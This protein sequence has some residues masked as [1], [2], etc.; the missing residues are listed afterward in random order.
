MVKDILPEWLYSCLV[1]NY[2]L[3]YIQEIRIRKNQPIQIC[4]QGKI[5]E[6]T[7]DSGLY[8]KSIYATDDLITYIISV[9]TKQS[10]YAYE[11][12]IKSGFIVSDNGI[13][14]GLCGT[15]VMENGEVKFLK[16]ITSLNIRVGHN[17][18]DCSNE[19]LN[20]LVSS[21]RVKN[22]LI[23]SAPGNGKTTMLRDII[24][25]LSMKYNVANIMVVDEKNEIAGENKCFSLGK[26]V[27]VLQGAN[28]RFGFYESV[29]VMNPTVIATDELVSENDIEG[30]KFAI[31]SGVSVIATMHAKSID[32]LKS[33]IYFESII[34][35]KY[36]ERIVVLS[37]R[38]GVGTVEGVFDENLFALYLP[39]MK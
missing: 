35:D 9:A 27:D 12:Q 39:Y 28:K 15:A 16:K 37:K 7:L 19:I 29:K 30:V 1:Q 24:V 3:D 14:I 5:I 32:D 33:K 26:S 18:K 17:I 11:D 22:T 34:K 38:K 10:L 31:K 36:F 23:I 13:R 4:Y 20:Y 21:N 8:L 25:K 2:K 6:P